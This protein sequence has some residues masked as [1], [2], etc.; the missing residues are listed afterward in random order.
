M[1]ASLARTKLSKE[2]IQS[3]LH[4]YR[5]NKLEKVMSDEL[6]PPPASGN[7]QAIKPDGP[8]WRVRQVNEGKLYLIGVFVETRD[9][10]NRIFKM[11]TNLYILDILPIPTTSDMENFEHGNN[12]LF[13][14]IDNVI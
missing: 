1:C 8:E 2:A 11:S 13:V 9:E 4:F 12:R 3:Q 14:C 5:F 7:D 10:W 6:K